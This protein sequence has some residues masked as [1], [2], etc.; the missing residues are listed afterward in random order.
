[1]EFDQCPYCESHQLVLTARPVP[2]GIEVTGRCLKCGYTCDSAYTGAEAADD[3]PYEFD[4]I[5]TARV[6]A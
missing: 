1:M 3:L 6:D 4:W 2:G 5:D